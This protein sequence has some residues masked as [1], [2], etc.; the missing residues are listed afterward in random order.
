MRL[1]RAP[2][3][4]HPRGVD[5][6]CHQPR[7]HPRLSPEL[8]NMLVGGQQCVLDCVLRVGSI[9]QVSKR[10]PVEGRQVTRQSR[11]HFSLPVIERAAL[12][13]LFAINCCDCRSH[14][15]SGLLSLLI[16]Q[17]PMLRPLHCQWAACVATLACDL[18]V[19]A[20]RILTNIAAIFLAW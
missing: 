12:R 1:A 13:N 20:P 10:A 17:M 9:P 7:R 11:R 5:Y 18:D 6:D 15:F 3:Q 19:F 4:L 2:A 16:L 14:W 8:A